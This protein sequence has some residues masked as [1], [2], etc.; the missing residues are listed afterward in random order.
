MNSNGKRKEWY[1]E[2]TIALFTGMLYGSTVTFVGQ[3][4]DTVKTKM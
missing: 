2:G 3:P 1:A 4:F